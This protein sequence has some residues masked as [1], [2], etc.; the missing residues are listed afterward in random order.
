MLSRQPEPE[1][2]DLPEEAEAYARADFSEVNQAFVDRLVEWAGPCGRA[3]AL[4]L[5]TGPA[6]IPMRLLERRPHWRVVGADASL[7]MLKLALPGIRDRGLSSSLGLV[8]GDAKRL[9]LA[10]RSFDVIFSNSILHHISET[11]D[12][13]LEVKRLARPGAVVL[14][15][16]LARPV[17]AEAARRIVERYA[18]QESPLLQEEYYRSLLAAYTPDEVRSQLV[19]AGLGSLH[20]QMITDRHMDIAGRCS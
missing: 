18:G 14:V 5:G 9:P 11:E 10:S 8:L 17:T 3:R 7:A 1:Y 15:R 16:D 2:M 12:L 20:V 13:W 6:D 4:D 19:K